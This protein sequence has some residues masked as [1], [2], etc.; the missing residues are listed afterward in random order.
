MSRAETTAARIRI[1]ISG[2]RYPPWRGTFYPKT[3]PQRLELQYASTALPVIEINGSFYSLQSPASY[4]QWHAD[5]PDDFI[6]CVKGPR[7]VTHMRRLK[8]VQKP[9]AN[10]FASGLFNL[11]EK[12]GPILWQLPPN[13]KYDEQRL[14]DFLRL[15]PRDLAAAAALARKRDPFMKGRTRL[16]VDE[17]RPLRH[18]LEVRNETF[19][20]PGYFALLKRHNVASVIAESAGKWPLFEDITANFVYMRLHGD[21]EIY[22]SG[23]TDKSLRAWAERVAA[24]HRGAEPRDARMM[25][26][27]DAAAGEVQRDVFCFFDNT[28]VKLRAPFD[29]Q[30]L[31]KM[32]GVERHCAAARSKPQSKLGRRR[33]KQA[34]I[35]IMPIVG[36][37]KTK[38]AGR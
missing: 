20:N 37:R 5:T 26:A 3:L 21:T 16:A 29:A 6:F 9:L 13:F 15:L 30:S 4:A 8:D 18:A 35:E 19:R 17:N 11:R 7:Y 10:F 23:Y 24:W 27:G 33:S 1:G 32:L 28:D 31:A 2:W 14:E 38:P 25:V 22:R 34:G 36:R 12:L